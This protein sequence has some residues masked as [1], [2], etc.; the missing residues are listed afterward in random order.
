MDFSQGPFTAQ[1][2]SVYYEAELE[3]LHI[4]RKLAGIPMSYLKF[5]LSYTE[6]ICYS[7]GFDKKYEDIL[8]FDDSVFIF[9]K[10]LPSQSLGIVYTTAKTFRHFCMGT[11]PGKSGSQV[12]IPRRPR[13]LPR[14]PEH[15]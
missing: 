7:Y 12:E 13:T 9:P 14:S 6:C 8:A 11:I 5:H 4:P 1:A 2:D 10:G 15:N 3:T